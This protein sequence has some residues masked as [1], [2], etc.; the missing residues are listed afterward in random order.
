MSQK[1]QVTT[2]GM[3]GQ[4]EK[5][6]RYKLSFNPPELK[7]VPFLFHCHG[8]GKQVGWTADQKPIYEFFGI[9]EFDDR[10]LVTAVKMTS[11]PQEAS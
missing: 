1:L 5:G 9:G 11:K 3:L 10:I 7:P 2:K 8:M 4:Y 6:K